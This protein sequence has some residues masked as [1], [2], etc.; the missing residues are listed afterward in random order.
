MAKIRYHLK[1]YGLLVVFLT[2]LFYFFILDRAAAEEGSWPPAYWTLLN[3]VR[4]IIESNYAGEID[5][6][7]LEQGAIQGMIQALGDPYSEYLSPEK[8][9][10]YQKLLEEEYSGVGMVLAEENNIFTIQEVIPSSPAARQGIK[11]GGVLLKVDGKSVEGLSLGEVVTLL[12]GEI[13]T[14]VTVEIG[15]PWE[16]VP[17]TF[18]LIRELIRRPVVKAQLLEEKIG[19]LGLKSFTS[20][21]PVEVA[22][23]LEKLIEGGARGIILDLRGNSGGYLQAAVKVASSF[24]LKGAPV[25]QVVDKKGRVEILRSEGPGLDLPVVALVD[26]NTA[27]AAEL[28]AGALQDAGAALLIGTRTF[29]KG[30]IQSLI[31]LSDG[32]ALK[33]TTDYYLTPAGR[34]IQGQG[35]MPDWEVS[36]PEEQLRTAV[37]LLKNQLPSAA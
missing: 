11:P 28:L 17:R 16:P 27:S 26:E 3:E 2:F 31:P 33:L 35:I 10:M 22:E 12:R 37:H 21:A 15:W 8:V 30:S 6:Y 1:S 9:K 4:Y 5:P 29:G 32:G 36:D 14:Q 24:L 18:T 25:A 34:K 13:G 7:L 23:G 20:R 19:Y